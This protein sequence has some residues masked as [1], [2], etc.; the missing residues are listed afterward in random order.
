VLGNVRQRFGDDEVSGQLDSLGQPSVGQPAD[1]LDRQRSPCRERLD[2]G[3]E[4]AIGQRGRMNFSRARRS[5]S[6]SEIDRCWA[7]SCR[8]RSSRRRS[9]RPSEATLVRLVARSS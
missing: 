1:D 8:S 7:P 2:G 9:R 6:T 5:V 3:A 4:I